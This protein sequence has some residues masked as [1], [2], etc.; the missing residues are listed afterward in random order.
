MVKR[1]N[2][3]TTETTGR[4]ALTPTSS[5]ALVLTR[6]FGEWQFS[7]TMGMTK[8]CSGSCA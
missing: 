1:T 4:T 8:W 7:K 5:I 3:S 6:T 2:L